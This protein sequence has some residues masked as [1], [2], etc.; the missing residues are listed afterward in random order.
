MT[1]R[2]A[3]SIS[4]VLGRVAPAPARHDVHCHFDSAGR[5][6]VCDYARCESPGVSVG[7][8]QHPQP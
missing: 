3:T 8:V 6:Y 2:I 7:E 4:R 5:P 1:S